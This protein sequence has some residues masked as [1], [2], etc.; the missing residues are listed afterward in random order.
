M[1]GRRGRLVRNQETPREESA[2]CFPLPPCAADPSS[3]LSIRNSFVATT[4]T[5][6]YIGRKAN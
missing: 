3:A 5:K 2:R 4:S 1:G 6:A